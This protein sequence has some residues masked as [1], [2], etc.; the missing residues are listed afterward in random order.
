SQ[1]LLL[2]TDGGASFSS[3]QVLPPTPNLKVAAYPQVAFTPD[4]NAASA[5]GHV[6]VAVYGVLADSRGYET[7]TGGIFV[8]P[9]GR[10]WS[11]TA[12]S[13]LDHGA[14][15][16]AVIRGQ[17]VLASWASW[18]GSQ[19]TLQGGILCADDPAAQWHMSCPLVTA[20]PTAAG[21]IN[22]GAAGAS[23]APVSPEIRGSQTAPSFGNNPSDDAGV[24]AKRLPSASWTGILLPVAAVFALTAALLGGAVTSRRRR[25]S[26]RGNRH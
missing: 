11:R 15:G 26:S 21:I 19:S 7:T 16:V 25:T 8:S 3:V 22:P 17:R 14:T 9:D 24:A 13:L 23:A 4:F 12:A 1:A 6:Y 5:K 18:T 2:S 20:S 10:S